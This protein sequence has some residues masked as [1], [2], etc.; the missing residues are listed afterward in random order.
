MSDADDR[1]YDGLLVVRCQAGDRAAFAELVARYQPR[2]L[3]F[4]RK[5][6]GG[7]A[8]ADDLHQEVWLEVFRGLARLND[9][10]A[11]AAWVYRVA[12]RRALR[13]LRKVRP[14][15]RPL[16][17]VDPP[18]RGDGDD[19]TAD[20][21]RAVHAALDRLAAE[22]REVLLLRYVEGLSYDDIARVVGLPLGTVRSRIHYAKRALRGALGRPERHDREGHVRGPA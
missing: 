19:F 10:Y 8:A 17:G 16:D 11:F 9:P 18:A 6:L 12:R 3:Y 20:D 21:A 1:L 14:P 13:E 4:L 7:S 15:P 22:H 2:L 5:M